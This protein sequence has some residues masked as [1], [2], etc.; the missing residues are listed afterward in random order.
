MFEVKK[1]EKRRDKM[2]DVNRRRFLAQHLEENWKAVD[3]RRIDTLNHSSI[4]RLHEL[5]VYEEANGLVVFAAI[6]RCKLNYEVGHRNYG[7]CLI[8]GDVEI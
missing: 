1:G 7:Q 8:Q 6:G 4:L 3:I 2:R 5:I